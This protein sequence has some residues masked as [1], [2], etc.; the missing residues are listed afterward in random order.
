VKFLVTA[1]PTREP[2]DAMR[3]IS[4]R[5]SGKMGYALAAASREHG[6]EVV[7]VSGPTALQAPANVELVEVMTAAEMLAAVRARAEWCDVL[8]M[9]AA[10]AD[11][12]PA[13]TAPGKLKKEHMASTLELSKTDDIL[14]AIRE[15]KGNRLFIGFAA[16]ANDML[17]EAKRKL[18]AKKLDL[19]VANDITRSDSGCGSDMNEATLIAADGSM[20]EIALTTKRI[21]ADS[22]VEWAEKSAVR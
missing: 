13:T 2:I 11:W 4:N 19:I 22:I 3:F 18:A 20:Q 15:L 8:L 17:A 21:L 14:M 9:A 7:L 5:S 1:G 10:V 12:R 6:H 16:E